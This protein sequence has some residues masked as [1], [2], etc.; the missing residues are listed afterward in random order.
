MKLMKLEGNKIIV[1]IL[2]IRSKKFD[3]HCANAWTPQV[4]I[5]SLSIY[6][7]VNWKKIIS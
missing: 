2:F 3:T 7:R 5:L 6:P 1:F 4:V